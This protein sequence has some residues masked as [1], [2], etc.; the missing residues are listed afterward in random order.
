[1]GYAHVD[2]KTQNEAH[3]KKAHKHT[4]CG[5]KANKHII[6]T[7]KKTNHNN[8]NKKEQ[9]KWKKRKTNKFKEVE[10][11]ICTHFPIDWNLVGGYA[12]VYLVISIAYSNEFMTQTLA[13]HDW[14]VVVVVATAIFCS[15]VIFSSK[16]N[17]IFTDISFW[18]PH[19][20]QMTEEENAFAKPAN[21]FG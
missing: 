8:N 20:I 21:P 4:H 7:V 5:T 9:N 15:L 16:R 2:N 3:T 10:F 19:P 12:S 1:M 17:L 6:P 18:L 13:T 14:R 11:Y